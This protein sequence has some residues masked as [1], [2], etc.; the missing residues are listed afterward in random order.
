MVGTVV[1]DTGQDKSEAIELEKN[2]EVGAVGE[3]YELHWHV[4][5]TRLAGLGRPAAAAAHPSSLDTVRPLP[6]VGVLSADDVVG[7]CLGPLHVSR[8]LPSH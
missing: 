6:T 5:H 3:D 2:G 7:G 4:Q 1:L 8:A